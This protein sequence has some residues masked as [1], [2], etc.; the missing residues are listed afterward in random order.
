[1]AKAKVI[2]F[3][4]PVAED[5]EGDDCPKCPPPGAPAWLA[6]FADIATN[7][8]A[9]FV[10]ILGFAQF[11][12]PSF[13]K[14]AGS[15]RQQFGFHVMDG[16]PRGDTVIELA[17]QGA[18][19]A[20]DR[21]EPG[22]DGAADQTVQPD[23]GSGAEQDAGGG[24]DGISRDGEGAPGEAGTAEGAG[25]AEEGAAEGPA[26]EV[27]RALAEALAAGSLEVDG[28]GGTVTLRLPGGTDQAGVL[29]LADAIA[30]VAG[31]QVQPIPAPP[32]LAGGSADGAAEEAADAA[33][34]EAA[35]GAAQEMQGS[36]RARA[37][38]A[39]LGLERILR[40]EIGDGSLAVQQRDGTV[41]VTLGAGGGFAS[42]SA[43]LST[44]ARDVMARIATTTD[45]PGR[46]ITVTGHTDDVPLAG[47]PYRDNI[48]LAAARAAAV[49][50]ELVAAGADPAQ[51]SAVSQGEY[52]P[53][54]D[55][56]TEAGR[57]RNRRIEIEINYSGDGG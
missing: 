25:T 5:D 18:T 41:T 47:G 52:R 42:G 23:R 31:G 57:R 13:E 27:A 34:D 51:L 15:M 33:G 21:E 46:R 48:G 43:D 16:G 22:R 28:P 4:P 36:P 56:A 11:D 2:P 55:N 19:G 20:E 1:M 3:Q 35:D 9:F 45:R 17:P 8:M 26:E 14:F 7:L 30:G 10:L 12:E 37:E 50:R 24:A 40:D 44:E 32:D 54:A 39:A 6:T 29:A 49:A 38:L 53:V